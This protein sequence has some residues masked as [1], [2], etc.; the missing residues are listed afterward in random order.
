MRYACGLER[1]SD[2]GA[3]GGM[4][5]EGCL[6][7]LDCYVVQSPCLM[8]LCSITVPFMAPL[9]L[10]AYKDAFRNGYASPKQAL[11]SCP[12]SAPL[13]RAIDAIHCVGSNADLRLTLRACI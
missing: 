2:F 11:L 5:Y 4:F 6:D 8:L 12:K 7:E 3:W 10:L 1:S 13:S 9:A